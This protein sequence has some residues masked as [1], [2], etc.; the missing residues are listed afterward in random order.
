MCRQAHPKAL[1]Y[2]RQ[3]QFNGKVLFPIQG[4]VLLCTVERVLVWAKN[5]RSSSREKS[6]PTLPGLGFDGSEQKDRMKLGSDPQTESAS[7]QS[8]LSMW[9]N[10]ISMIF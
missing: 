7:E 8:S 2:S 6:K 5:Y 1:P 4:R 3:G 10:R 9:A